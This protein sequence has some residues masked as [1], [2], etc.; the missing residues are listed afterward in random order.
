MYQQNISKYKELLS[1]VQKLQELLIP[2]NIVSK[3]EIK[4]VEKTAKKVK[5]WLL[6]EGEAIYRF[7]YNPG[8]FIC[9]QSD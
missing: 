8:K 7:V 9:F 5:E 1:R 4:R 6:I 2:N 3:E